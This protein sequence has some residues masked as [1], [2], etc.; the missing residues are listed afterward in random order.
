MSL[1]DCKLLKK[2]E[3][4]QI[5]IGCFTKLSYVGLFR[6]SKWQVRKRRAS[7]SSP[8]MTEGLPGLVGRGGQYLGYLLL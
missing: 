3:D 5:T 8:S 7:A 2:W 4:W 1:H 6:D